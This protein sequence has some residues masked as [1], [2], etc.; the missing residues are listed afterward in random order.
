MFLNSC[1][2]FKVHLYDM[3]CHQ[4][5]DILLFV[6]PTFFV[7]PPPHF[8]KLAVIFDKWNQAGLSLV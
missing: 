2:A 4:I 5:I 3:K 8:L 6:Y 7:L 1:S